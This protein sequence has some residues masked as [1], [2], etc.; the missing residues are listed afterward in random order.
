M[1]SRLLICV[2]TLYAIIGLIQIFSPLAT[3]QNTL[4]FAS[5]P[6]ENFNS[7][8][9]N[10]RRSAND[11]NDV[12]DIPSTGPLTLSSRREFVAI[13]TTA[14]AVLSLAASADDK[15]QSLGDEGLHYIVTQEG[16][17]AKPSPG[18]KVRVH[19]TGWL[20]GFDNEGRKF[21]S[22]RDRRK[23][24]AFKAGVGQVITGW[25]QTL[26]DMKVGERRKV[27]I[28]SDLGYGKRGAGGVIP[29]N[30]DLYFDMELLSIEP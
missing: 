26:L 24:L 5:V 6:A 17:G 4:K 7:E 13:S 9:R 23:P 12:A 14:A 28:P 15:M 18:Q 8:L 27:I 22:S 20:D 19:Y 10:I 30:A 16:N 3:T 2:T 11:I 29:P 25:D 21:D 1:I